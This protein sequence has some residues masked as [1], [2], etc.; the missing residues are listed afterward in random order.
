MQIAI[1]DIWSNEQLI[2]WWNNNKLNGVAGYECIEH[3]FA[4][5][6]ATQNYMTFSG[7]E[8]YEEKWLR[9]TVCGEDFDLDGSRL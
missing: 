8:Q 2:F 9:C 5:K 6:T 7:V 4:E 1:E 3:N